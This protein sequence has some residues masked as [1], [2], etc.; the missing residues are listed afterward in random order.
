M[1][2]GRVYKF[3]LVFQALISILCSLSTLPDKYLLL[4]A[5]RE[6]V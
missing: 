4:Q 2:E 6:K 1:S 3:Y 5:V